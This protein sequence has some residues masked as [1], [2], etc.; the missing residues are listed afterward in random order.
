MFDS[1]SSQ[2]KPYTRTSCASSSKTL[3][4]VDTASRSSGHTDAAATRAASKATATGSCRRTARTRRGASSSP[5]ARGEQDHPRRRPRLGGAREARGAARSGEPARHDR[6]AEPGD[7]GPHRPRRRRS[8]GERGRAAVEPTRSSAAVAPA[9]ARRRCHRRRPR[10]A[11][12]SAAR[13]RRPLRRSQRPERCDGRGRVP[14]RPPCNRPPRRDGV[15]AGRPAPA[16]LAGESRLYSRHRRHGVDA[17]HRVVHRRR[18]LLHVR[19]QRPRKDRIAIAASP[20][21][22]ARGRSG[23][24]LA[25][26][27][28]LPRVARRRRR[29]FGAGRRLG[30][31]HHRRAAVVGL[32]LS[33]RDAFEPG[34]LAER[35]ARLRDR[36][37]GRRRCRCSR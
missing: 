34:A 33:R 32:V 28:D 30:L 17:H 5:A 36:R 2:L 26:T 10:A 3:N 15:A 16:E 19:R 22:G 4:D 25:R 20:R 9:E 12:P 18:P 11:S 27:D 23:R 21:Q 8:R 31:A 29:L 24:A 13:R 7:A 14:P 1:G 35:L 6:R 37:A